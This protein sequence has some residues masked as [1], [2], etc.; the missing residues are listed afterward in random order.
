MLALLQK[1]K[2]RLAVAV[3]KHVEPQN[4]STEQTSPTP[5][6]I[7]VGFADKSWDEISH[8]LK[9][10]LARIKTLA[11]FEEKTP[12]KQ[13]MIAKYKP[14]AE[15]LMATHENLGG[16]DLLWWWF[17]W[18]ID[19]GLFTAIHDDFR[20]AI[21]RGLDA[22][23]GWKSDGQ[24]AFCDFV[25]E[26]TLE[27]KKAGIAFEP[28][29]LTSAIESI[30]AGELAINPALKSKMYRLMGELYDAQEDKVNAL[31]FYEMSLVL[32]PKCGKKGRIKTLKEELEN[33]EK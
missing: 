11:G 1:R 13:E 10:D 31:K 14:V 7:S 33:N 19:C 4:D 28:R 32:D 8:T 17:L 21:E 12:Y 27:S 6:S 24:T 2:S 26:Y 23:H 16:L 30:Q 3:E 18:Q 20:Q 15:K 22:P 5:G 25:F 9:Q 29:F